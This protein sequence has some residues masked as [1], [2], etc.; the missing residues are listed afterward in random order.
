MLETP[1]GPI[2]E[3]NAIACYGEITCFIFPTNF[4]DVYNKLI[5]VL[6]AQV[7]CL[8][9]ANLLGGSSLL[10]YVWYWFSF[11]FSLKSDIYIFFKVAM[12]FFL[13]SL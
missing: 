11:I 7:T 2:F 1:Y 10:E 6:F 8:K 4:T 12:L 3:S 13:T 5:L 9:D